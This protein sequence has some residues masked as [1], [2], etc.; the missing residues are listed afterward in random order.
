M[1]G[2]KEKKK[3]FKSGSSDLGITLIALVI[4]VIVLLILAGISLT[5]IVG[6]EGI[7]TKANK[8]KEKYTHASVTEAITLAY[9]EYMLAD[10]KEDLIQ[11]GQHI[12]KQ[13]GQSMLSQANQGSLS[14]FDQ[15]GQNMNGDEIS[16]GLNDNETGVDITTLGFFKFLRGKGYIDENG[17]VNVKEI[18]GNMIDYGNGT[19]NIDVYKIEFNEDTKKYELKY[20]NKLG[21]AIL[22]W[23][24]KEF[25]VE[26]SEDSQIRD[27]DMTEEMVKPC[28]YSVEVSCAY[29][30]NGEKITTATGSKVVTVQ[31]R[32]G[33]LWSIFFR[34]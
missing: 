27:T 14:V 6:D 34:C 30:I 8:A 15:E 13:E 1:K 28:N 24:G 20:Y 18:F 7:F 19:G 12:L 17:I 2:S 5:A 31:R 25:R 11:E 10:G 21:E 32:F 23:S 3:G 29:F 9:A 16:L 22:L 26:I 4:T 33:N